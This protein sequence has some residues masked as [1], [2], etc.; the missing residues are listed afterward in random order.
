MAKKINLGKVGM[1]AAGSYQSGKAYERLTCVSYNH[2]S[3]VS[4]KDVPAGIAPAE[5]SEY[6]QKMASRG[7]QGPQGQSYVDKELV[8]IVDNLTT[9]GSSNVLSAEQGKVLKA[10]LTEL[11]SKIGKDAI[12][13]IDENSL[14]LQDHSISVTTNYVHVVQVA[15]TNN[16]RVYI[17]D[18]IVSKGESVH[19]KLRYSQNVSLAV[20]ITDAI[21][22]SG[23]EAKYG[24]Q[25]PSQEVHDFVFVMPMSGYL[26]I[27]L[28]AGLIKS[29]SAII[30]ASGLVSRITETKERVDEVEKVQSKLLTLGEYISNEEYIRAY[31]D[32]EGKFLWGIRID[33][34]IEFAK[35]VPTPVKQWVETFIT[36]FTS[37]H[38]EIDDVEERSELLLDKKNHIVAFRDK[39]G[40]KH[41]NVGI[42]TESFQLSQKGMTEFQQALKKAG[43]SSGAGDHSDYKSNDGDNPLHI[44]EPRYAYVNISGV[45][46]MPSS[47]TDNL[48]A[49]I[50]VYDMNGNFFKKKI[51][52]NA[53]GS[54]SLANPQKNFA[55]DLF[56]DEWDGDAF[57]LKIGDWVPQDSFHFKCFYFDPSKGLATALFKFAETII[58]AT[59][60]RPNRIARDGDTTKN[61]RDTGAFELDYNDGA[62]CHPDGFPAVVYLNGNFIGLFSW[63]LKK[64]RDNYMMDKK[65]YESIHIDACVAN[66][67]STN[68][69]DWSLF[70]V[71]NPKKLICMDGSEYDGDAP[72]EL[73]DSSS[74]YYNGSK[75]QINTIITKDLI[76]D[77]HSVIPRINAINDRAEKKRLFE[78]YFDKD[79]F[80]VFWIISQVIDNYDGLWGR[81]TQW[82]RYKK[83]GKWCPALYDLDSCMGYQASKPWIFEPMNYLIG[84]DKA[85]PYGILWDLY[86]AEIKQKYQELRQS[87]LLTTAN[88]MHFV[89]DW[90][91][92]MG[93]HN[94]KRNIE[95]WETPCYRDGKVN[96][97]YWEQIGCQNH[98]ETY[99]ST[100]QYNVGDEVYFGWTYAEAKAG[101]CMKYRCVKS[102]VGQTPSEPYAKFPNYGGTFDSPRRV[103]KWTNDKFAILDNLLQ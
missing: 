10:E 64:H 17:S 56:D 22:T 58:K 42:I 50:E 83:S 49:Y 8:P 35:G 67:W 69:I 5:G 38:R 95:M 16:W 102:C 73:I 31:T 59:N 20:A 62:L 1:T 89:K 103:E 53:Q 75:D 51:L 79:S 34:S 21:P 74:P 68:A 61:Y 98:A 80:I 33:G 3:W 6:W 46:K 7:E 52:L 91:N 86:S 30:D 93:V 11:D 82:L 54:S 44:P 66:L 92:R 15:T 96:A 9:G 39:R 77:L 19:V 37:Y 78:Q 26:C 12:K 63:N 81:N 40:F 65:D 94:I 23:K 57:S 4:K 2:E 24:V 84:V 47:K 70:E 71:R 43:F 41:E 55:I 32:S 60:T 87:N 27:N 18:R 45:E 99:N 29:F 28:R 25:Y 72:K 13:L 36:E 76:K 100:T 48:N 85:L 101:E 90:C 97:E 88:L 14:Y